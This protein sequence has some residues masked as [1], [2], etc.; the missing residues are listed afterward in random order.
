MATRIAAVFGATGQQGSSVVHALLKD[1][2]F[3]PRAVT[4]DVNSK[5]ARTLAKLGAEVVSADLGGDKEAVKK[6]VTGAEVVFLVTIPFKAAL[7]EDVQGIN[8]IDVSKEARVRFVV[9]STLPSVSEISNGKYSHATQCDDKEK[10]RK[11]LEA[12][13][14]AYASLATGFFFE[15]ILTPFPGLPFEKSDDGYVWNTYAQPGSDTAVH[16]WASRDLGPA[17]VALFTQYTTRS[18][19]IVG[20]TFVLASARTSFEG[21]TAELSKGLGKP[22]YHK[23]GGIA[24]VLP[25]DEMIYSVAEFPW[26]AGVAIP[27]PRLE[28]LGVKTGTIEEFGRTVLKSHLGE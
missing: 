25:V 7:P 10:I 15:N 16:T 3:M 17:V 19:E 4:R 26:Y 1:G 8:V 28:K 23:H 24:G 18:S 22:V 5:S 11:Y 12:S 6:A 2:T 27:D 20:Q 14:V 9:F 13:G 21:F